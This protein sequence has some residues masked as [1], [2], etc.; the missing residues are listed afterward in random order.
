MFLS[1]GDRDL[2]VPTYF[3]QGTQALSHVEAWNSTFFL[4]CKRVVRLPVELRLGTWAL[5]RVATGESDLPLCYE[6]KL[7]V[8]FE[9]LQENQALYRV[10]GE[11]TVI[12]TCSG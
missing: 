12:S 7:G 8:P 6:R 4:S 2:G 9:S 1:R 5:S 10:E 3:Q 11:L